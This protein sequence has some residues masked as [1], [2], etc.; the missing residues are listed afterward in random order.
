MHKDV[1]RYCLWSEGKFLKW[2][3]L[4]NH[5]CLNCG[6]NLPQAGLRDPSFPLTIASLFMASFL[7]FFLQVEWFFFLF[8]EINWK[9][10]A[11]INMAATL[12]FSISDSE[13]IICRGE[14]PHQY[15][16]SMLE[17]QRQLFFLGSFH[18]AILFFRQDGQDPEDSKQSTAD[19]TVF[20]SFLVNPWRWLTDHHQTARALSSG[21]PP[22]W[23]WSL[24]HFF[25]LQVQNLLLQMVSFFCLS[26]EG[27]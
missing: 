15:D 26:Q 11:W 8:V 1:S 10:T 7:M 18:D 21:Q 5:V 20:V 22:P 13:F 12:Y 19:M 4:D 3:N 9:D 6:M 14:L 16:A 2:K 27:I 23:F 24:R 17:S 25:P